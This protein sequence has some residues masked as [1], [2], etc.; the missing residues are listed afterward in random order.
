MNMCAK[1]GASGT[2]LTRTRMATY[3]ETI[4]GNPV[5][6]ENGVDQFVCSKCGHT[7][8]AVANQE[9]LIAAVAL[10][11]I[12]LPYKL[13]GQEIRLLRMALG[14]KGI[15]LAKKLDVTPEAVSRWENGEVIGNPKEKTLRLV[16][17]LAVMPKAPAIDVDLQEL[18]SMEITP[19]R[20]TEW[21]VINLEMVRW[22]RD[23][24]KDTQWDTTEP[25]AA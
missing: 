15:E 11:R 14:L 7:V 24:H 17:A 13:N 16:I 8:V 4:L 18:M 23:N 2:A 5:S 1:C 21:P 10:C 6:L 22:K 19:V 25:I 20:P 9:G 3:D 12:L